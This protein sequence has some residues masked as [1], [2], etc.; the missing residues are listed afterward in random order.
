VTRLV[1]HIGSESISNLLQHTL[2]VE[3]ELD[4]LDDGL[5]WTKGHLISTLVK[6]YDVVSMENDDSLPRIVEFFTDIISR[7]PDNELTTQIYQLTN[8]QIFF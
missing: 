1:H 8:S 4:S 3:L 2:K 6:K 7:F 5:K